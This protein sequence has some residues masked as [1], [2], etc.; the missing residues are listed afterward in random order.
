MKCNCNQKVGNDC[1]KALLIFLVMNLLYVTPTG[2]LE[3]WEHHAKASVFCFTN[4]KAIVF[5]FLVVLILPPGAKLDWFHL[6]GV[7]HRYPT[8]GRGLLDKRAYYA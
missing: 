7:K 1:K 2:G 5:R 3:D 4:N 6:R 8:K